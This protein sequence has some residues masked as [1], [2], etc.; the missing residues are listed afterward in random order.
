MTNSASLIGYSVLPPSSK[1][2]GAEGVPHAGKMGDI[3]A[4]LGD[5]WYVCEWRSWIG[6]HLL[7]HRSVVHLA[8]MP[9]WDLYGPEDIELFHED[10]SARLA[11][12]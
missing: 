8:S 2:D 11:A 6:G 4:E 5:G 12:T 1:D 10:A 7:G 3:V 9:T